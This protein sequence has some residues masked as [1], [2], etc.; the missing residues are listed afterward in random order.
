MPIDIETA[1]QKLVVLTHIKYEICD[2]AKFP[3]LCLYTFHI[4]SKVDVKIILEIVN[5][6]K[7]KTQTPTPTY[8]SHLDTYLNKNVVCKEIL[9]LG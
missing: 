6:G 2:T 5:G 4:S 9:V 3:H 1:K 8:K 7:T